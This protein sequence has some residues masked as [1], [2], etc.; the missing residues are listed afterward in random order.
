MAGF[1]VCLDFAVLGG[2]GDSFLLT[3]LA[4]YPSAVPRRQRWTLRALSHATNKLVASNLHG[5]GVVVVPN[6]GGMPSGSPTARV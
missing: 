3:C 1:L 2:I 4:S 5:E 6:T